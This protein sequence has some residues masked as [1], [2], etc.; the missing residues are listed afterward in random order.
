MA[1][2]GA[3][4]SDL[5]LTI[6]AIERKVDMSLDDIIKQSKGMDKKQNTKVK[7]RNRTKAVPLVQTPQMQQT[8][9]QQ[10][11]QKP[12]RRESWQRR[13]MQQGRVPQQRRD[14][15]QKFVALR[16]SALRQEKLEEA[17]ARN[18]TSMFVASKAGGQQALPGK[19]VAPLNRFGR[20]AAQGSTRPGGA[21]DRIPKMFT[22]ARNPKMLTV[23]QL[24]M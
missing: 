5:A 2:F 9:M 21:A 1:P 20:K 19:A 12:F 11:G 24:S 14:L 15:I 10:N 17:R 4:S 7:D 22:A 16:S 23:N 3:A 13:G 8:Q 6:G 18:G